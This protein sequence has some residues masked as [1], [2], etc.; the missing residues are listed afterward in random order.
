M[1]FS[2]WNQPDSEQIGELL[3]LTIADPDC[4]Y[5][6]TVHFMNK[7][8]VMESYYFTRKRMDT[9][10]VSGFGAEINTGGF[11]LIENGDIDYLRRAVD[12]VELRSDWLTE[13]VQNW[14]VEEIIESP[15]ILMELSGHLVRVKVTD[16]KWTKKRIMNEPIFDVTVKFEIA[17]IR[18]SPLV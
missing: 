16:N 6:A 7:F 3:K 4:S 18:Y 11:D 15:F 14:L 12:S 10:K 1:T 17:E 13:P 5:G 2:L 8:G 9:A